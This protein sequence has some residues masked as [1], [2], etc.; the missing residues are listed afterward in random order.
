MKMKDFFLRTTGWPVSIQ[1]R[2][3]GAVLA[4]FVGLGLAVSIFM[5]TFAD[6]I[7]TVRKKGLES[8]V[9]LA[10]NSI[11]PVLEDKKNGKITVGEARLRTTDIINQLVYYNQGVAYY[12]FLATYEGYILVEPPFPEAVGTYQ[13]QKKD[14]YGT[15][16]TKSMLEKAKAGGGFVEY[17][18]PKVPGGTPQ[19]KI[20]Y[21]MGLPEIACYLGTGIFVDDID[22]SIEQL[23]QK[24]LW[25]GIA[26]IMTIGILQ[27]Y[28]LR[29]LLRYQ[30][31]LAGVFKNLSENPTTVNTVQIPSQF[32]NL[33]TNQ[34]LAN[35]RLMLSN[36][37]HHQ[38]NI[39]HKFEKF[40]QIIH[41]TN[42]VVWEWN[43]ENQTTEWSGNMKNLIGFEPSGRGAHFEVFEDWVYK[44][45]RNER[46]QALARYFLGVGEYYTAEYRLYNS[47]QDE[48]H[49]VSAR[50]VATFD[51]KKN[52]IRFVGTIMKRIPA[53]CQLQQIPEYSKACE[54]IERKTYQSI[55]DIVRMTPSFEVDTLV[56]NVKKRLEN[57]LW[58]GVVIVEN[59]K[60]VG[61]VMRNALD[62]QLSSQYGVSLYSGRP[63]K[64]VMDERPLITDLG[65]SLEQVAE[66]ARNRDQTKQYDL[67]VV[68]EKDEYY[69]TISVMDLLSM[70]TDLRIML[71]MNANPLTG[72]P[73]NLII[74]EKLKQAVQ[75][76][77]AA[78]YVDL[79]NFKAFNDKY[80][81]EMGDRAIQLTA[82][83]LKKIA[84]GYDEK[85]V[86][87]GHIGGDD[88]LV[89]LY[90][91]EV[92]ID[93]AERII[94]EFDAR[95]PGL[96]LQED[97]SRGY[98]E[99]PDRK[100]SKQKFP[101]MSLSIALI[102][103]KNR[104]F[105]NHLEVSEVAA[106]LKKRAKM[107]EGSS[108][109]SDRRETS[110]CH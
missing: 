37:N 32:E 47:A 58:Q 38:Q 86:F 62:S 68:T 14:V 1:L 66:L 21:V 19:K 16:I 110:I 22:A 43:S 101:V 85:D 35:L 34:S 71:A 61:L 79:D 42:D 84:M 9:S 80:G 74:E 100:G 49:W 64:M 98:I 73:G 36:F 102:D 95:I 8:I 78:L 77:F 40:K 3:I 52:P 87:L 75:Q 28:F 24:F 53:D 13:M 69:G 99:V 93:W 63:I 65:C 48:H 7:Y 92:E 105:A 27:Y 88:F 18:E 11:N 104:Q 20:S 33:D 57:E 89:L 103:N 2:T 72:L 10:Q 59:K 54:G 94:A 90:S 30:Y 4:L 60:P 50:G 15:Q 55:K 70:L 107:N 82:D 109:V 31:W 76:T 91:L 39:E 6:D 29:P 45:E 12:V 108:W 46:R 56:I 96:Y 97:L 83:I 51:K 23:K 17:Y 44:E 26:V 106:Q 81:F 25:L 67:I 41:A 5:H